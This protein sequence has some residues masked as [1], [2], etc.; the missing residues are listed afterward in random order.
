VGSL[1]KG[2]DMAGSTTG[3]WVEKPGREIERGGTVA[4]LVV[5]GGKKCSCIKLSIKMA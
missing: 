5:R 4:R 1:G 3:R 2:I